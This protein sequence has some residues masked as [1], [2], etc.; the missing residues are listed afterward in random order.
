MDAGVGPNARDTGFS[1]IELV[2]V[3]AVLSVL[4]VGAGLALGRGNSSGQSDMAWFQRQF[5]QARA[6][7]VIRV[8]PQ[9]LE[10]ST[11]GLRAARQTA[12]G[13]ELAPGQRRWQGRVA[14]FAQGAAPRFGTPEI[15]FLPNGQSTPFSIQFTDRLG[16]RSLRCSSDGWTGLTCD[17]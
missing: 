10:V 14:F 7:A 16:G 2:V 6:S 1:L 8:Q 13:W 5:D 15:R 11:R 17:G 3:V 4:A 12:D 9:G